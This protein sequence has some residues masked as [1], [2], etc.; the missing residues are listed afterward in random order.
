MTIINPVRRIC[1]ILSKDDL[2]RRHIGQTI[3]FITPNNKS[4]EAKASYISQKAQY[5]PPLLYGHK[6]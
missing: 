1:F 6:L 3:D 2:A 5:T 4:L